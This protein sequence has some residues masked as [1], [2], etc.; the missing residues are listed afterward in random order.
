MSTGVRQ[1]ICSP[2]QPAGGA[3]VSAGDCQ[4]GACAKAVCGPPLADGTECGYD[5][6]SCASGL[7][8]TPDD[9]SSGT[10]PGTCGPKLSKAVGASC[11]QSFECATRTCRSNMCV[12]RICKR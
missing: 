7:C 2:K 5:N 1:G 6:E 11:A 9:Q 12:E 8:R 10:S 3:C 4:T